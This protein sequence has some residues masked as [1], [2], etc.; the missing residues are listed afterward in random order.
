MSQ[1]FCPQPLGKEIKK[2]E[3]GRAGQ[4]EVLVTLPAN[5][6]PAATSDYGKEP[7]LP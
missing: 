2:R 4:A 1:A 5:P 6:A 7:L 3:N